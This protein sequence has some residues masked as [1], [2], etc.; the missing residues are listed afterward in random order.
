MLPLSCVHIRVLAF[1]LQTLVFT[2]VASTNENKRVTLTNRLA[3]GIQSFNFL[4]LVPM[5]IFVSLVKTRLK[6]NG[7]GK[8][9]QIPCND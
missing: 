4:I 2:T 7:N 3:Q 1:P 5:L 8:S 6:R 9:H